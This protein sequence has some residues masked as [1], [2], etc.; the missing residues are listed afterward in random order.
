MVVIKIDNSISN[1]ERNLRKAT[2]TELQSISDN[3]PF[4]YITHNTRRL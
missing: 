4:H 3:L 2:Y 1:N